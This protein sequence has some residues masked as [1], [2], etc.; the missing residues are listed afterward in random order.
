MDNLKYAKCDTPD[1]EVIEICKNVNLHNII[2]NM[3]DQ[4]NTLVGE[5]GTKLSG[6]QRQRISIV[7]A[8]IRRTP[9]LL[10]DEAT[11]ALD[12][13]TEYEVQAVLKKYFSNTTMIFISHKL[14]VLKDMDRIVVLKDGQIIE[15]G[16]HQKLYNDTNSYYRIHYT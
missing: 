10:L 13:D 1:E 3:P 6:G 4:Y 14:S 9:I 8:L 2:M 16:S 15:E 7:R 5:R 12:V 11:S